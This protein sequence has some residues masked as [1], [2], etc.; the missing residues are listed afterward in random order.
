MQ[1][2]HAIAIRLRDR[3]KL[4][5]LLF[6]LLLDLLPCHPICRRKEFWKKQRN[7][8]KKSWPLG[9]LKRR[10]IPNL[11]T[12]LNMCHII[13]CQFW[14]CYCLLYLAPSN[15]QYV[16]WATRKAIPLLSPVH[17]GWPPLPTREARGTDLWIRYPISPTSMLAHH[18][19]VIYQ[20]SRCFN[21][22]LSAIL[23]YQRL[24]VYS[25]ASNISNTA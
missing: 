11:G 18:L 8:W 7:F 21:A 9:S 24:L 25:F 1:L 16:P 13:C 23:D 3:R 5:W 14:S 19:V 17:F 22:C 6:S 20:A 10:V 2:Q 15:L 4:K 12:L